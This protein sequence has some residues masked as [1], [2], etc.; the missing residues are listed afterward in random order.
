MKSSFC[1]IFILVSVLSSHAQTPSIVWQKTIGGS[2]IDDVQTILEKPDGSG[3]FIVGSTTSPA[4]FELDQGTHGSTDILLVS[5]DI[6][7]QIEWTN[8]YGGTNGDGTF[9][10]AKLHD[11]KLYIVCS[12]NSGITGN[13]T[14]PSFGGNDIW[15]LC[16]DLNGSIL[17]QKSFGGSEGE[18]ATVVE[19]I[20]NELYIFGGSRSGISGNKT[21]ENVGEGD[22]WLLKI[23]PIDGEKLHEITIGSEGSEVPTALS[24]DQ[25]GN[26]Y[27]SGIS[28]TGISGHKTVEGKG[29]LDFW[30]VKLNQN[31]E[32]I[33]QN[34]FGTSG[35]DYSYGMIQ[36]NN[37]LYFASSSPVGNDGDV[38]QAVLGS[39][40]AWVFCL[41][42]NLTL[43]WSNL[44]GGDGHDN[45]FKMVE[46]D[47]QFALIGNTTSSSGGIKDSPFY[48]GTSDIWLLFIDKFNGSFIHEETFGGTDYEVGTSIAVLSD[49]NII[50][51]GS[52]YSG[53]G[54][55]KTEAHRGDGDIWILELNTSDWLSI[56]EE[57]NGNFEVFPNPS[58]DKVNFRF[59]DEFLATKLKIFSYDGK[60]LDEFEIVNQFFMLDLSKYNGNQVLLYSVESNIGTSQGKIVLK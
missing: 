24:W 34:C 37:K 8:V 21:T 55:L 27:L 2:G 59:S 40:D 20:N 48:G 35:D 41:D 49:N 19:I 50:I 17:W 29:G 13:K 23:D 18:S 39:R 10:A 58:A 38:Q 12:S 14:L 15:V 31:W 16:L 33:D 32:I 36:S 56:E 7:G 9:C 30:V 51:G 25:S 4:G 3:F 46:L 1:L 22:Y 53:I 54:G 60:K 57:N 52:S 5:V 11:S 42:L 43:E 47:D 28:P 44:Y 45:S 26:L 6:S